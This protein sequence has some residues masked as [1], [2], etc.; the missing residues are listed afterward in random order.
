[1]ETDKHIQYFWTA[2]ET[3]LQ[4]TVRSH[5]HHVILS[6]LG[7]AKKVHKV[8]LHVIRSV[9]HLVILVEEVMLLMY[10]LTL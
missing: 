2:L 8:C 1:M 9:Y 3:L 4:V 10:L 6:F 5:D 7:G